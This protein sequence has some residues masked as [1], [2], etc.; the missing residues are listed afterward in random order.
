LYAANITVSVIKSF[1][2][3]EKK[4]SKTVQKKKY[5]Q[6]AFRIVKEAQRSSTKS[7]KYL[8]VEL[9]IQDLIAPSVLTMSRAR[10]KHTKS[11]QNNF[12]HQGKFE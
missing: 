10:Q 1:N 4:T 2:N 7:M 12:N 11:L 6:V 9:I 3:Q 5:K 8:A